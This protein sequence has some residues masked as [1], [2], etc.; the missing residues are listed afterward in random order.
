VRL[1]Q[2]LK[3][4][5]RLRYR[6]SCSEPCRIAAAL[7]AGR[8]TARRLGAGRR[9]TVVGRGEARLLAAG[10]ARV[11]LKLTRR[12]APKLLAQRR[13][14]LTLRTRVTDFSG[15]ARTRTRRLALQR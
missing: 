14:R 15:N 8:G 1:P 11:T 7:V 13:V 3:L 2:R 12:A 9:A 5:R 6:V 4:R 10:T